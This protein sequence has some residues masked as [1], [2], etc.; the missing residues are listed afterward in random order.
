MGRRTNPLGLR[1][2]HLINWHSDISHP[3]LSKYLKH[4]FQ[5][6]VTNTPAIRAS[7]SGIWVN[8]TI[9]KDKQDPNDHPRVK[10]PVLDFR[11]CDVQKALGYYEKRTRSLAGS[12]YYYKTIFKNVEYKNLMEMFKPH[13]ALQLPDAPVHLKINVIENPLYNADICAQQVASQLKEGV[14]LSKIFKSMLTLMK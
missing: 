6:Y 2:G 7:T 5:H 3:F 9:L 12:H 4:I 13:E 11:S 10:N 8:L 1:V 14:L